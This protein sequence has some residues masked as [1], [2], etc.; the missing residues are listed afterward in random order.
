MGSTGPLE[1]SSLLLSYK[2]KSSFCYSASGSEFTV[3]KGLTLLM[4]PAGLKGTL[5]K[6]ARLRGFSQGR[7]DLGSQGNSLRFPSW[8]LSFFIF[9]MG[10]LTSPDCL[11]GNEIIFTYCSVFKLQH[12][13]SGWAALRFLCSVPS[14]LE[15]HAS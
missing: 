3:G 7:T 4:K 8:S 12:A 10:L 15:E 6:E 5:W 11:R 1:A 9:E 2:S 14:P 13:E